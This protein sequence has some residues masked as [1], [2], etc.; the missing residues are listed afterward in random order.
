MMGSKCILKI[1]GKGKCE[2]K[3]Y[4]KTF[5]SDLKHSTIVDVLLEI[6]KNYTLLIFVAASCKMTEP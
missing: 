5:E 6:C 3:I 2:N 1:L 4:K